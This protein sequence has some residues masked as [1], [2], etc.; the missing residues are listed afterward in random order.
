MDVPAVIMAGRFFVPLRFLSE[1]LGCRVEW[2]GVTRT[3]S[4]IG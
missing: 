4:I 1:T 3:V 2:D